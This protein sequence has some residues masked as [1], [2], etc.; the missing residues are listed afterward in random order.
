MAELGLV[1]ANCG[2]LSGPGSNGRQA[3]VLLPATRLGTG[4][5]AEFG[6]QIPKE[7]DS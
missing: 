2:D 6:L 4:R 5:A 1:V 7:E 3:Q